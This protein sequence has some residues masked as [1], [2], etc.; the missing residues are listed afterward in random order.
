LGRKGKEGA[1]KYL[2]QPMVFFFSFWVTNQKKKKRSRTPEVK[3][4]KRS[5]R[6]WSERARDLK[7]LKGEVEEGKRE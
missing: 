7:G 1:A 4:E 3:E 5:E 6:R 2:T